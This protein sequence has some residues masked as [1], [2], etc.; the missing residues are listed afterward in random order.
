MKMIDLHCDTISKIYETG[1]F[2]GGLYKNYYHVDILRLKKSNSMAQFFAIWLDWYDLIKQGISVWD[3]FLDRQRIFTEQLEMNKEYIGLA[4]SSEDLDKLNS[5]GRIAAFLTVEGGEIFEGQI[6]RVEKVYD[7]GVRLITLTWNYINSLAFPNNLSEVDYPNQRLTAFGVEVVE[8]MN[9]KGMIVD[10]SH[11]S[12]QGFYH[13]HEISKKPYIASHSN[14]RTLKN[15]PRNLSDEMLKTLG[16]DGGL[17]GINFLPYF[18]NDIC[19]GTTDIIV[20]HIQH[21]E[22][23]SGIESVSLGTDFDGIKGVMEIE[24]IGQMDKLLDKLR[25]R[26]YSDDKIEKIWYKNARRIIDD[27]IG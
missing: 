21:I 7:L 9:D 16:N 2:D 25:K 8:F 6:S 5:E 20:D 10:V 1:G 23:I 19:V 14:A 24:N 15:V 12:D 13:V 17:V 22:N 26:G 18:L 11:L 27:V 3:G 4:R